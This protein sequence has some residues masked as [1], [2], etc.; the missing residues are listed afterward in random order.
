MNAAGDRPGLVSWAIYDWANS[1]FHTVILTFVFA[2][3]FTREVVGDDVEGAKLWGNAIGLSGLLVAILGPLLGAATDQTGRRKPWIGAFTLVCVAATGLLWFV[4]PDDD[5]RWLGVLLAGTGAFA[6]ELAIVFYNAMLPD[7]A[8]RTRTGRWSGWAWGLGYAG[9]LVCLVAVLFLFVQESL[10]LPFLVTDDLAYVR[11]SFVFAALWIGV[12]SV[13]LLVFTPDAAPTGKRLAAGIRDGIAQ[14]RTSL[15]EVRR[16][17][18]IVRFLVA[19]IFYVDGLATIFAFGGVFAA[20]TFDM[21]TEEILYFAIALN[22]TA[23]FGAIVFSW[24]DD[25]LGS[26][27]TILFA[28]VGLMIAGS[29]MLSAPSRDVFWAAGL[30][31]GV[32]VGPAQAASRSWL[33]RAAPAEMRN[34]MFGLFTFSGKATAFA[35]PLL[36]GWITALSGSQ[37]IGMSIVIVFFV[38]GFMILLTVPDAKRD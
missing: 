25:H 26:R 21:T 7:L 3:Y 15:R 14:L 23:G 10:R 29:I 11:A 20:G 9:G 24:L 6:I 1:A 37:R 27:R 4:L 13:P 22:V 12:F 16:Y 19:R 30:V 38:A 8:H 32:F 35:G 33:A 17:A 31:L 2:A 18:D 28:L 34:Q 5:Y 36:V